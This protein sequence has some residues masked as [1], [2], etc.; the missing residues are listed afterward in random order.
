MQL[1]QNQSGRSMIEMLAVLAIIGI[2]SV[3]A[4]AALNQAMVKYRTSRTYTEIRAINQNTANLYSYLRS[5]PPDKS[6]QQI[7]EELCAND[8]FPTECRGS[9]GNLKAKNPFA[10]DYYVYFSGNTMTIQATNIPEA[11]CEEL[12]KQT[13]GR[14][15][16][17]GTDTNCSGSGSEKTFAVTMN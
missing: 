3:G 17:E 5:Y 8:V 13:W 15:Q 11:A 16:V 12:Q 9:V 1:K 10:G 2:I 14:Y 4:I 6:R 7:M